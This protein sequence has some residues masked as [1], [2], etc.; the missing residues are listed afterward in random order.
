[1]AK[2]IIDAS[3]DTPQIQEA[4]KTEAQF[5]AELLNAK[6]V[7]ITSNGEILY[8]GGKHDVIAQASER[9]PVDGIR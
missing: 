9:T 6:V 4:K 3:K 2:I 5:I 1:M 8:E 7:L